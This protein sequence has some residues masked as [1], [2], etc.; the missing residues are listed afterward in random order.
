MDWLEKKDM[1][2]THLIERGIITFRVDTELREPLYILT[3]EKK[4]KLG[5]VLNR[6]IEKV[7]R[8]EGLL[9]TVHGS[10]EPRPSEREKEIKKE[11][12]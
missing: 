5:Y 4:L 9:E 8:E 1:K 12:T 6:I 7:L 2:T 11:T 10:E 3:T